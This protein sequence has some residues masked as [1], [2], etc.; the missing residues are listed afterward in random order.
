MNVRA[1]AGVVILGSLVACSKRPEPPLPAPT[2]Q[3]AHD[4][5]HAAAPPAGPRTTLLGNLGSYHRPIKTANA[6]AQKFFDEG[7]TL[8]YGFNHEESFQVV[9]ARRRARLRRRRCRTGACRWRSAPTSTTPAPADRLQQAHSHLTEAEKR[10]A[11]RQ[12]RR[13]GAGRR[14]RPSATSR[15][16]PAIKASREQAYSDAMGE[17]SKRFPD[18]LDVATL[19]AESLMNLRPWKLYTSRRHARARHRHDRRARSSA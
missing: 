2:N 11:E 6:D 14:A 8:L 3:S 15:I 5:A 4:G 19:Y 16:R 1:I 12:R 7:L 13:A 17:V 18:D 9:R 10:R